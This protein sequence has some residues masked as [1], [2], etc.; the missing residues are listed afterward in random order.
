MIDL[1]E[2]IRISI[3]V[4]YH[5]DNDDEA[6]A[7]HYLAKDRVHFDLLLT[8]VAGRVQFAIIETIWSTSNSVAERRRVL[9]SKRSSDDTRA[10]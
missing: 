2:R 9:A 8:N 3:R 4:A 5:I 7:R 1:E 10:E 6:A